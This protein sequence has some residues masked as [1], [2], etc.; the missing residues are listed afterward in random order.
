MTR[1]LVG[2][3]AGFGALAFNLVVDSSSDLFLRRLVG[4]ELPKPGGEG[5]GLQMWERPLRRSVPTT[6]SVDHVMASC[7]LPLFFPAI[8][9]GSKWFGDGGVR[10]TSPLSPALHLGAHRILAISTQSQ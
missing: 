9:I 2:V 6:L 10:L 4:Y 3:V 7:A 1:A 5:A 8:K